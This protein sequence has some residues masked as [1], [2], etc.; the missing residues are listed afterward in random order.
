MKPGCVYL[1]GA[2][3]GDPSLISVRGHRYLSTADVVVYDRLVHHR[4][5]RSVRAD[6]EQFDVGA[7]APRPMEQ[8]AIALLLA[9]KAQEGKAVARLKWGDPFV[10][11]GGGREALSLHKQGIPFEVVPGVPPTIGGPC[12]A[13]IPLTY[14]DAGDALVFIRG[15]EAGN[16]HPA[17]RR[18]GQGGRA[19]GN[20]RLL[21]RGRPTGGNHR[22]A[23]R[24]RSVSRR[25][26]RAHHRRYAAD[27]ANDRRDTRR[28][29]AARAR[30]AAAGLRRPRRGVGRA[31]P[32][33]P[34]LVRLETA[35]RQ[36][37]PDHTARRTGFW[38]RRRPV[39]PRSRTNRGADNQDRSDRGR[40][41]NERSL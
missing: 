28:D 27:A 32:R 31:L 34:P 18:L 17:G 10:F 5:L 16:E 36:T 6:A 8:D 37:N 9:D 2:G 29:P 39:E 15:H 12:Y 1:I 23:A 30:C 20:D 41:S 22:P 11:D 35:L 40:W 7:A 13:G 38:T 24:A 19:L 21:C 26:R 4:L 3:P 25:V 14:P 33:A